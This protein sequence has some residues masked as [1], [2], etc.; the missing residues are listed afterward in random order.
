MFIRPISLVG[1][2]FASGCET[3]VKDPVLSYQRL[4]NGT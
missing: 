4:K 2:V 1:R 3:G